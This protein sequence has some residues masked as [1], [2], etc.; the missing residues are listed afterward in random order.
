[1]GDILSHYKAANSKPKGHQNGH[2]ISLAMYLTFDRESLVRRLGGVRFGI[3][4][5]L[6]QT[7]QLIWRGSLPES[8][9]DTAGSI[10][11]P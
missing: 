10:L 3:S 7:A 4:S 6:R 11:L 2:R 9:H 5:F 8:V 1:M